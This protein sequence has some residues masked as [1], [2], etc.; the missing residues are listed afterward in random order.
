MKR[1]AQPRRVGVSGREFDLDVRQLR[2]FLAVVEHGTLSRAAIALG[3]AQSTVSEALAALDR[4]LGV[5]T[6]LRKRG[7]PRLTV[8][9][10]GQAL[11]PHAQRALEAIEAVRLSVVSATRAASAR[12]EVIANESVTT[13][14]LPPVLGALRKSWPRTRFDISIATC[15]GIRMQI[16]AG[17]R[18]V[19]LLLEEERSDPRARGKRTHETAERNELRSDLELVVFAGAQH[20]LVRQRRV[21]RAA[22]SEFPIF[23]S[24]AVGDFHN[25]LVG[26]FRADGAKKPATRSGRHNR[27]RAARS[28]RRC[29]G[30]GR[31]AA[32]CGYRGC[33]GR[34]RVRACGDPSTT[35]DATSGYAPAVAHRTSPGDLRVARSIAENRKL[36]LGVI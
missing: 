10:A 22:L 31:L 17:R 7:A 14:L 23:I 13:Y 3:L 16:A 8:T 26:Y 12:V 34:T 30:T 36:K 19:G 6:V 35:A 29:N 33:A 21:R 28:R 2:T 25:M 9:K 27:G 4:T 32:V 5:P 18:D 20:P 24:D 1:A 11:I 15:A